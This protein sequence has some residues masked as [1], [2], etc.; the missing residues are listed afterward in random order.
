MGFQGFLIGFIVSLLV[1]TSIQ[2]FMNNAFVTGFIAA[3]II[4]VMA[5]KD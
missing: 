5:A 1:I 2:I 3:T 4:G